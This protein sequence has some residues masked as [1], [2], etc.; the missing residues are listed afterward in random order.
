MQPEDVL[1]VVPSPS[2]TSAI[3][4]APRSWELTLL[5]L[6][7][8][9][10]EQGVEARIFGSLAWQVI[11]GLD[12]LTDRS[13]LDFALHVHRETQLRPLADELARIEGDAPMRLDGELIRGGSAVN[14]RELHAGAQDVLVKTI[15]GITLLRTDQFLCGRIPA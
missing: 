9:A 11:T 3:H 7:Q 8:L 14:W 2:L 12:Y 13:D 10:K 15:L 1:A 4:A 5:R 6:G